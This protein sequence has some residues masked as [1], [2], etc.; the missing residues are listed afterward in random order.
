MTISQ[1]L[2]ELGNAIAEELA[3]ARDPRLAASIGALKNACDVAA[4]AWSGSNIGYHATVYYDGLRPKPTGTIFS[5]EWGLMDRWPTHEPDPGWHVMDHRGVVAELLSRAG[6]DDLG[7]IKDALSRSRGNL[8][9]LKEQALSMLSAASDRKNDDF[10]SRQL[11]QVDDIKIASPGEIAKALMPGQVWSRDSTAMSQGIAIAPHQEPAAIVISEQHTI[12]ELEVLERVARLSAAHLRRME[13]MDLVQRDMGTHVVIGHGR[14]TVWRELKDFI[15][16]RLK[17]P[18]D[19]FNRVP[20]AGI[21]NTIRLTQMLD[22]AAVA[23]IILTAEDEQT[24][25]AVRARQNVV[26][27]AGLFQGRL[28]FTK[29]TVMLEEGCEEFSNIQGL[30]QLR[31]PKGNIAAAFEDVRRVLERE[32]IIAA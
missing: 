11:K 19:E 17:L 32:G 7:E 27:E 16:D 25:G 26:H 3:R 8:S 9:A 22:G 14:S 4:R 5:P 2:S 10:L 20:V 18:H 28:G 1:E 21:P 23:L 30:G 13:P 29:A 15:N 6:I 12:S 31:F 24:D